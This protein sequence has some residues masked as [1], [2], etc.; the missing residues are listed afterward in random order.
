M[1]IHIDRNGIELPIEPGK[2][3]HIKYK[4]KEHKRGTSTIS[5]LIDDS[6][7]T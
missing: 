5:V 4:T 7:N 1:K 2:P 3:A 6:N